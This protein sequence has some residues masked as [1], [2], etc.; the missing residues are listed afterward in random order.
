MYCLI[1][2]SAG[3]VPSELTDTPCFSKDKSNTLLFRFLKEYDEIQPIGKG[4]FGRVFKARKKIENKYVAVKIVK[5]T[6]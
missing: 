3:N 5:R 1:L 6:K 2:H 4:G